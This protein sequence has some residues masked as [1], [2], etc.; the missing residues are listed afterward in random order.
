MGAE[1]VNGWSISNSG[2]GTAEICTENAYDG[3]SALHVSGVGEDGDI[4]VSHPMSEIGSIQRVYRVTF[5]AKGEYN[6]DNIIVGW[7]N[8]ETGSNPVVINLLPVSHEKVETAEAG[9]GWTK[10][11]YTVKQN[12]GENKVENNKNITLNFKNAS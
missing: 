11:S 1:T 4:T 7:G 3:K 9:D 8:R 10:Y 6:P 2:S 5:Y 12:N